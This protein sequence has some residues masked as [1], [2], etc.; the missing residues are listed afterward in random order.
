MGERLTPDDFANLFGRFQHEAFR[1]EVQ[2]TYVVDYERQAVEDFLRGEPL[3]GDQYPWF[4][5]WLNQIHKATIEGR[6]VSRVRITD[7][8][9]T[10]Y[11]RFEAY[12]APWNI[13]AG[14]SLRYLT[15]DK[16]KEIGLPTT[17]DWWLFDQK[18]LAVMKFSPRGEAQGGTI[19]DDQLILDQHCAWR[20]LA[21]RNSTPSAEGAT[22]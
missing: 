15:R 13:A 6:R 11:Q 2:S 8:P 20:D 16:A 3:P 14:E 4:A 19:V 7:D 21:V 18:H 1:L 17:T 5:D 10:P 22:A 9:L 12:L